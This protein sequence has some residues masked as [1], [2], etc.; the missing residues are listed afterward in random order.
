MQHQSDYQQSVNL[1]EAITAEL[2]RN[3][4][5]LDQY[6]EVSRLPGISVGFVVAGIKTDI[7]LAQEALASGDIVKMARALQRL[8]E[9]K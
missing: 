7:K 6:H 5:L 1:P 3:Q 4:E 2:S 9:N 8:Q